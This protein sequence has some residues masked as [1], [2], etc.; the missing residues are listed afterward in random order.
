MYVK[1]HNQGNVFKIV[2]YQKDIVIRNKHA[3]LKASYGPGSQN[4]LMFV[5]IGK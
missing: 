1:G 2:Y 3:K 5:V 4:R